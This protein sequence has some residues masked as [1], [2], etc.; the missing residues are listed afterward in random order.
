MSRLALEVSDVFR[1]AGQAYRT[2]HQ[3]HLSLAHHKVC[4]P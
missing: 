3:G 1:T 4:Q 2:T